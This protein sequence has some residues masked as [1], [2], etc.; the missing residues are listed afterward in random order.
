[1]GNVKVEVEL[2]R[3]LVLALNVEPAHLGRQARE[4]ILLE[5]FQEG[6]ISSGKAAELL[7]LSKSAFLQLLDRRGL[8]FLD[9]D[10]DDLERQVAVAL[11]ASRGHQTL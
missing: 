2:P 6:V 10:R 9:A 4:W 5:L 3:E 1:M 11:A 7:D 8:V